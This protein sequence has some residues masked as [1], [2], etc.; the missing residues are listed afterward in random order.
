MGVVT[1]EGVVENGRVRLEGGIQLPE[2]TKVYVL[3]P[4]LPRAPLAHMASPRLAH[5]EQAGDFQME[6][7]EEP[8]DAGL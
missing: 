1:S 8:A 7:T 6:V 5:P 4:E 3:V 2:K